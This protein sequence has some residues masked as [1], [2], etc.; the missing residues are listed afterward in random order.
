[1]NNVDIFATGKVKLRLIQLEYTYKNDF[2]VINP[3][4]LEKVK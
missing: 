4:E 3:S 2:N 1:M